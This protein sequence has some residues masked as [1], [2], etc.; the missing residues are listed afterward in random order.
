MRAI[1]C[2]AMRG[3]ACKVRFLGLVNSVCTCIAKGDSKSGLA[4]RGHNDQSPTVG[5]A[6]CPV[7]AQ[8]EACGDDLL[9]TASGAAQRRRA[10]VAVAPEIQF[11][12]GRG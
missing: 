5:S 4:L 1:M 3:Q 2:D 7:G 6:G 9:I 11:R 12:V 8:A 10:A